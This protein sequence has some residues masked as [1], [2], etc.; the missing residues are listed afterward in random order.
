LVVHAF[1]ALQGVL[2]LFA[3]FEHAPVVGSQVPT[4]WH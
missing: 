2:L 3:G 1:P 4:S